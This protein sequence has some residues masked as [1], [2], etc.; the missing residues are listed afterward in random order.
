MSKTRYIIKEGKAAS[1]FF[2]SSVNPPERKALLRITDR[3]NLHCAHCFISNGGYGNTMPVEVIQ[4]T[5]IP[6]LKQC[7]VSRVTLTGGEPFLHPD[8]I[9]IAQALKDADIG[10]GICTNGTIIH[11]EQMK[12]LAKIRNIH[13]NVSLHG[14][15]PESHNRFTKNNE[16]FQKTVRAIKQL[17][18][19]SLLQGL[20][21]TPNSF[22]RV[23]EYSKLCDFAAE[24]G[25][26][27]VLMNPLSS[28]GRGVKS[29]KKIAASNEMMREIRRVTTKFNHRIQVVYV[30][31][32]NDRLPL[33]SCEAGSIIYV[34]VN[35]D[36]TVCPYLVFSAKTPTSK[37][38]P[39]EF[40]VGNIFHD[41]DIAERLDN[42][43]FH[44]RYQ[45]G[46][47]IT[48]KNCYL[49]EK[50]GKGCPAAIIAS[51]KKI[52]DVDIELCPIF[53][54]SNGM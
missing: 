12:I 40:I 4:N 47:N 18:K 42:Y 13:I 33:S 1:C 30:R 41:I 53:A 44:E 29:K 25:A 37:H 10:I 11:R 15:R 9:K 38:N 39:N 50:C 2:R 32:P 19:Y 28:M 8:I 14:F 31:F 27:Y 52:G 49:R 26:S 48:C 21:V 20:L 54:N 7:R 6:Q 16:A 17:G 24:N 51:G 3:C 34:F 5:V 23:I 45:V 43:K 46:N 35:G 36:V 22:A